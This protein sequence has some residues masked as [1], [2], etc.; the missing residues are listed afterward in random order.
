MAACASNTDT[1]TFDGEEGG[2]PCLAIQIMKNL[3]NVSDDKEPSNYYVKVETQ[4]IPTNLPEE[5]LRDVFAKT[6][7]LFFQEVKNKLAEVS[8]VIVGFVGSSS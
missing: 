4:E 5:S 2:N 3:E 8:L 1:D 7:F 6:T